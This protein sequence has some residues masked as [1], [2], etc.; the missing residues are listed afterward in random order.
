MPQTFHYDWDPAKAASNL[1]KH[2]VSFEDALTV[3]QDRLALS[4]LDDGNDTA[5]ERWITVGASLRKGLLPVVHT[6]VET[7]GDVV[8][9]QI[10][11]ARKPTKSERRQYEQEII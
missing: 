1:A 10:I 3:F 8:Y 6:H 7:D 11:S 4:K 9:I 2:K 5:E